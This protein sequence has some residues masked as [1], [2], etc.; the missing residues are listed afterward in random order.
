[1]ETMIIAYDGDGK[2]LNS[3]R[4]KSEIV[5]NA[6][7]YAEVMR[8]GLQMHREMDVPEGTVYLRTGI[9]DASSGKLG[10]LETGLSAITAAKVTK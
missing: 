1:M 10:S 2:I 5:L 6:Q 3:Y 7:A 9:M 4:K 8:V